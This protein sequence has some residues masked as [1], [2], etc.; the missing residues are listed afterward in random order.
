MMAQWSLPR[1]SPRPIQSKARDA[2]PLDVLYLGFLLGHGGDAVQMLELAAGV[3][4]RGGRVRIVLPELDTSRAF[5]DEGVRRG[6]EVERSPFVQASMDGAPQRVS[7]LLQVLRRHPARVLHVHTGDCCPPRRF[8]MALELHRGPRVF[9]TIQSPYDEALRK[10]TVRSR[11]WALSASRRIR[12]V[13][14]PSQ[15]SANV[16]VQ[17]GIPA[18]RVV[19]IRNSV[20]VARFGAGDGAKAR[21]ALGVGDATPLVLVTSRIDAQ[22]RPLDA[23]RAFARAARHVPDARLVFLGRGAMEGETRAAAAASGVGDR[24]LFVGHQSNVED[25]LA[26][27]TVWYLPTE[28]ENFS[29]AVLEAMAAGCPIVSTFCRGNDEV[30]VSGDNALTTAV[31]DVAAQA[32]ALT[33]LLTDAPLRARLSG[34]ARKAAQSFD[35]DRMVDAYVDCYGEA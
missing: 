15:A 29:L 1:A 17:C 11:T 12:R 32:E 8:L 21:R 26:A 13:I 10:G 35:V 4:R 6:V 30:L 5:A 27:G 7:H 20:A 23:V 31:G 18:D 2:R 16:Q 14:C 22:K 9:T 19:T 25:W 28:S 3:A 33:R 24:I 34:A